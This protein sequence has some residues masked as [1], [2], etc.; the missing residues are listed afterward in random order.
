MSNNTQNTHYAEQRAVAMIASRRKMAARRVVIANNHK[1]SFERVN[2]SRQYRNALD[3]KI[4]IKMCMLPLLQRIY[5]HGRS[6]M[7]AA[8]FLFSHSVCYERR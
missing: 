7:A 8:I 2:I 5:L 4:E 6:R 3:I 1:S